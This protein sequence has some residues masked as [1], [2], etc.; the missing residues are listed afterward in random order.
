MK[1]TKILI[2]EDEAVIAEHLRILLEAIGYSNVK[3]T[4]SKE[5]AFLFLESF[6]P[7][8]ILLDIR[9]KN[10]LDGI[11]I[12]QHINLSL[13]IPFIFITAHSDVSI[14]QKAI[15]TQPA[16]YITKPFKTA[17]LLAA[18]TIAIS[19][20]QSESPLNFSFK[21][22]YDDVFIELNSIMYVKS[23]KNYIDIVCNGNKY[24]LRNSLEWFLNSIPEENFMR[25]HRSYVVNLNRV[26][27]LSSQNLEIDEHIIPIS[28]K[29]ITEL[30]ERLKTN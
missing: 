17:D 5:S 24:S 20:I 28:R 26:K 12:A 29:F 10:E 19:K 16:A 4:H 13:K 21:D 11:E 27:K 3:M 25:V 8:L 30:R 2:I 18:I 7:D 22:G 23:D 6:K 1:T 9:M 15:E 14:I